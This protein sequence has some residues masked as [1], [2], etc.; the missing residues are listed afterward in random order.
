MTVGD[1]DYLRSAAGRVLNTMKLKQ[2]PDE[3][4]PEGYTGRE[5]S[6]NGFREIS[7]YRELEGVNLLIDSERIFFSSIQQARFAYICLHSGKLKFLVPDDAESKMALKHYRQYIE[8][9]HDPVERKCREA[10]IPE[11]LVESVAEK[12]LEILRG[13]DDIQ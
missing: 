10:G 13:E 2:F 6:V 5:L 1:E 12:C 3:F 11:E 8:S 7:M 9:L 4:M